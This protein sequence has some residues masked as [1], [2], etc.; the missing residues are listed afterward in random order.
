M[1]GVAF[2]LGD[3]RAH[4]H[5]NAT[6]QRSALSATTVG[7]SATFLIS[8]YTQSKNFSVT[9][10]EVYSARRGLDEG[11]RPWCG[12]LRLAGTTPDVWLAR[13]AGT[14]LRSHAQYAESPMH[15]FCCPRSSRC[16][17]AAAPTP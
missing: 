8:F 15:R 13:Q 6:R 3:V 17:G 12:S 5:R 4:E 14:A 2:Q 10:P 9:P 16:R 11:W 7:Y 1:V